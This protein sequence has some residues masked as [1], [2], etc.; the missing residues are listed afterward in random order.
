[1]LPSM[2][3][4]SLRTATWRRILEYICGMAQGHSRPRLCEDAERLITA[5]NERRREHIRF[6]RQ[7]ARHRMRACAARK[8]ARQGLSEEGRHLI[9]RRGQRSTQHRD[10]LRLN[11]ELPDVA[12]SP[13]WPEHVAFPWRGRFGPA[14]GSRVHIPKLPAVS[15]ICAFRAV[16]FHCA[17]TTSR[18]A[19]V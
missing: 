1:M 19:T 14:R 13:P 7:P 16:R 4:L 11:E 5:W 12:N 8:G 18:S 17:S 15:A 10:T 3:E 6:Q 9:A 2:T